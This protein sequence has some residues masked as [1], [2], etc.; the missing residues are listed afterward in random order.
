MKLHVA[1][2]SPKVTEQQLQQL[3]APFGQVLN[4]QINWIESAGRTAGSA[5]VEMHATEAMAAVNEL[6]RRAFRNRR[7]Y[8]TPIADSKAESAN[9]KKTATVGKALKRGSGNT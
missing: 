1:N 3:F 5:I 7:L 6:N 4:I 8:I 9:I 2:L